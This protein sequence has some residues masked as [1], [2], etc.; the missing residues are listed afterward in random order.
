MAL[1]KYKIK[2]LK[3]DVFFLI[4]NNKTIRLLEK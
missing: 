3:K 1:K 2:I 4:A